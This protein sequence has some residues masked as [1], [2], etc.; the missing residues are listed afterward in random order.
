MNPVKSSTSNDSSQPQKLIEIPEPKKPTRGQ[1]I[2]DAM[3]A[4][5]GSWTFLIGQTTVLATWIGFNLTPGMPHWDESPFIL[6]N[7][8]FSFASA[9][10]APIV[11]MSQ[12]R[13]SDMERE[14]NEYDHLVNRQAAQNIELLHEKI[15]N[16]QALQIQELTQI[17]REQQRSINEM[18]QVILPAL[19]IQHQPQSEMKVGVLPAFTENSD[20]KH[21]KQV[22]VYLP[23]N[24]DTVKGKDI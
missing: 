16:L 18:R 2:A 11:L 23:F 9:Y 4:K 7:L 14:K 5:V 8:V 22:S 1:R 13:Q 19:Q 17:V 20:R 15:D 24:V 10:T 12:N 6:L 3:A 21:P